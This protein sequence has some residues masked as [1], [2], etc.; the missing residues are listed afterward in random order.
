MMRADELYKFSDETLKNVQDEL[1][2]RILNFRLGYN[3]EM[4]RRKWTAIDKKI[5]K[6]RVELIDKKMRERRI[7]K[8][9]ERL[10][11]AW[12]LKMDYKL[13]TQHQNDTK[14]LTMTMEILLEPTSNKL[15][16]RVPGGFR[17][18]ITWG[19]G[20][21]VVYCSGEVRCTGKAC[22]RGWVHSGYLAGKMVII[23][24]GWQESLV[25][26]GTTLEANLSTNGTSLDASLVIEGTALEACLVS[27]G[28]VMEAFLVTEVARL[29]ASL[30]NEIKLL[31]DEIS[32]LKY[33]ACEKNKTFAKENG[34]FDEYVHPLLNRKNEPDKKNQE[35]LKQINDLDN[36]LQKSG[37]TDQTLRMLLPKDDNVQTGKQ[38]LGFEN[39]N[40]NV[41]PSVLNKA[42]ELTQCLYNMDEMGKMNFL[43]IRSFLKKK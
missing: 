15:C 35:F 37:K 21:S 1:H 10:V 39:Q 26:E 27:E 7:I 25:T 36:R 23:L 3:D 17:G 12:E 43:I 20:V 8:N 24:L 31:N 41:N 22:G 19:V 5:S 4:S 13:M 16:S 29:E 40:D 6:L 33:Q 9:L 34:K 11:G 14:V 42:K 30:V 18:N 2:Y 28:A 32:Y 38:G